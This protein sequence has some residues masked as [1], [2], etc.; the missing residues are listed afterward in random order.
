M[1]VCGN[2]SGIVDWQR[3]AREYAKDFTD[4]GGSIYLNH[5]VMDIQTDASSTPARGNS[6]GIILSGEEEV[7]NRAITLLSK[8]N[9]P[10]KVRHLITCAGIYSDR[11][12]EM[13][14][15]NSLPKMIPFRGE[16]LLLKKEKA[17]LINGNIYPVP[18]PNFPFLGVHFTP[19]MNGDVWLGPNAVLGFSREGYS[20]SDVNL[21]DLFEI[22]TFQGVIHIA[23]K[24]GIFGCTEMYKSLVLS[25]Q[26]KELQKYVPA[27]QLEDVMVG[28]S[29]VRAQAVERDGTLVEDFIF[30]ETQDKILH[31]R[32]A[33]SPG[34][35]SSLAIGKL[36][37][38]K[39]EHLFEFSRK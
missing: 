16:Y 31:V 25:A 21:W 1:Y 10:I 5:A 19:R 33:P 13:T 23:L 22:L 18:N 26:V 15:G 29:G 38:N 17:N 9:S 27:L 30:D 39:A 36:I 6:T 34:A 37:V 28:P 11:V 32:N 8:K 7:H 35:T 3:V 4:T 20:Y 12:S 14:G 2:H 24:H